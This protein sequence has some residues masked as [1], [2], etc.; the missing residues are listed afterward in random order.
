MVTFAGIAILAPIIAPVPPG[1]FDPYQ[2]PKTFSQ[3]PLPPSWQH[4]FG[5]SGPQY[6]MDIFYAVIW[7][8]RLSQV[9]ALSV[10]GTSLAVGV[11]VGAVAGYLSG[12]VDEALMRITDIFFALPGLV[13]AMVLLLLLGR[14]IS[15][16]VIAISIVW[17]PSYARIM[18]GEFLR[19]KNEPYVEA[20]RAIGVNPVKIIFRHIMPNAIYPVV[21][22]A[23]MDVGTVVLVASALGFLGIGAL[24]G[25][26]EW[27]VTIS[28]SRN[29]LLQG[30]WW[31]TFFPGLI[32]FLFVLGWTLLGDGLRDVLDPRVSR[33]RTQ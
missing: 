29:W 30:A 12:I 19:I 7:G 2:V 20:A 10:V 13:L 25:T 32:I 15:T 16:L 5:T 24:P 6:Y 11:V 17:W 21:V 14:G 1:S 28:V 31:S 33:S 23:A 18:R 27:G 22:V 8:S 9:V 4:P 26:A 3:S